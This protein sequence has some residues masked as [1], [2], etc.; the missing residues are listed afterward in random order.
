MFIPCWILNLQGQTPHRTI[1]PSLV[2]ELQ[3]LMIHL[4]ISPNAVNAANADKGLETFGLWIEDIEK[5]EPAQWLSTDP[6]GDMY[7]DVG[8]V[9]EYFQ[10]I[11]GKTF[12]KFYHKQ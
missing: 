12:K 2:K 3:E 1:L 7:R 8:N 5:E 10:K 6:R 4:A 11:R 9:E